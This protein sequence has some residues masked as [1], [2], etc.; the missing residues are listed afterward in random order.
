VTQ[1]DEYAEVPVLSAVVESGNESIIQSSRLG[2]QVLRELETL[3]HDAV[4]HSRIDIDADTYR[5]D[6]L[7]LELTELSTGGQVVHDL[8][9]VSVPQSSADHEDDDIELLIDDLVDR[10]ITE[11]RKDI[12]QLL[13]RAR[14]AT[15]Y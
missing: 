15:L 10:H 4:P 9:S 1:N 2:R 14:E 7:D 3:R 6:Q 12:R 8:H 5:E 13:E 11:L